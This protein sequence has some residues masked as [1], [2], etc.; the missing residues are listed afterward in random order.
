[1]KRLS[2]LLILTP[3]A[4]SLVGCAD[5]SPPEQTP[6]PIAELPTGFGETQSDDARQP[7]NWWHAFND[8]TLNRL[9]DEALIAN[10]DIAEAAARVDEARAQARIAGA[11]RFPS[12]SG[13]AGASYSDSPLAGTSFGGF[14]GTASRLTNETYST[15]L[16]F[17]YELDFWGRIRNDAR[18]ARADLFAAEADLRT[19]RLGA[20]ADTISTYFEVVDLR[21]QIAL[22]VNTIDILQDRVENTERRYDRGLASSFE[23]YQL[24]QDY[25]NTQA[26]L[27]Q[28]ESQLTA[29]EGRLALLLGRYAGT[30]REEMGGRLTPQLVFEPIPTGLPADLLIQRPDVAAA[31]Q[32][33]EAARFRVGA[34]RAEL[35]PSL[36]L[37][38]TLGTQS[39]NPSGIFDILDNWVL[40]LGASLT[41]PLFQGGRIRANIDVAEARYAQQTASYARTVLNA[42]REVM[43]AL[44]D[45][46]EQRQRYSLIFGQLQE[47]E[48]SA[49]LQAERYAGG[50]SA[51][52]DYLDALR[53]LY[54]VQ[55]ALS[56]A[57]RDVA[58]ARLAVHRG[59][60]GGWTED[61]STP[62]VPLV[63]SPSD[64]ETHGS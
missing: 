52:T 54:Q 40:N 39:G 20:L 57:G 2:P 23:L 26:A 51:F 25:R 7:L 41:A 5:F 43:A 13:S 3:L 21:A 50:V 64:G 18:A 11:N 27:P 36:S 15:G 49:N 32:R 35:F 62:E 53:T 63:D 14:G 38:S 24:R 6:A 22:S 10:L 55:S 61:A 1:V 45:Y 44:E 37:S 16:N 56:G 47:A 60:G 19:A 28:R 34:R 33:F 46:E 30:L 59:L 48:A 12:V 42:Y 4:L 31:A 58:L 17:A 29:A 9:V 8:P